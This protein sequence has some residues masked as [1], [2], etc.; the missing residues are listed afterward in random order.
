MHVITR[1][2]LPPVYSG[3]KR[4]AALI[5]ALGPA[6]ST[7]ATG[8]ESIRRRRRE[9]DRGVVVIG[10]FWTAGRHRSVVRI[11]AYRAVATSGLHCLVVCLPPRRRR[12]GRREK[13]SRLRQLQL[14]MNSWRVTA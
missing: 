8:S 3:K 13:A 6:A 11:A 14:H 1:P 7:I 5:R 4:G 10:M 9:S 12:R 2:R